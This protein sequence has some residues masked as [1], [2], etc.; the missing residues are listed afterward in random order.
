M[1]PCAV[2]AAYDLGM[3]RSLLLAGI[4]VAQLG[5]GV[6]GTALAIRRRHA[7]GFLMLHGDRDR[8]AREALG[9]GTALSPPAVMML[10]Q[11]A[12]AARLLRTR[13]A[14]AE[15]VLG[16]LGAGMVV[17]YLGEDLVRW[18]LRPSGWDTVESPLAA[19]GL[20]LAS[21]MAVAGLSRRGGTGS[22][23][24]GRASHE[25]RPLLDDNADRRRPP[26]CWRTTT[27]VPVARRPAP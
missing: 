12:A 2:S 26:S 23:P 18:R 14:S 16:F 20:A 19:I 25:L 11:V 22:A 27:R 3:E 4:S 17:G 10:T 5:A 9:M 21:V 24:S 6:L 8:V 7:Y 1:P 15:R 13:S